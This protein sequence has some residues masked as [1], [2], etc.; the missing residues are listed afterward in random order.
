M[1]IHE[2]NH[3][4]IKSR[5]CPLPM[6]PEYSLFHLLQGTKNKLHRAVMLPTVLYICETQSLTLRE[7]IHDN[8][9]MH[10]KHAL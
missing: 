8:F 7:R 4:Q 10:F 1:Y 5:K 9:V 3:N 6:D 2:K